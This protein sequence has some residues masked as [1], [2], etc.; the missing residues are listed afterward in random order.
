MSEVDERIVEGHAPFDAVRAACELAVALG[1]ALIV[2]G[3]IATTVPTLSTVVGT[4][5]LGGILLVSGV[6]HFI[7]VDR[8]T[9]CLD[10]IS[11]VASSCR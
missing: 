1:G 4:L 2:L 5:F 8:P 9:V 6:V 11:L 3:L 10:V 7:Q